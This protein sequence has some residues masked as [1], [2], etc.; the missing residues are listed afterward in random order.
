M[1]RKKAASPPIPVSPFQ[2]K[3]FWL[4]RA[5]KLR[6]AGELPRQ[7]SGRGGVVVP[8]IDASLDYLVLAEVRRAEPGKSAAER[9]AAKL[10]GARITTVY[11]NDLPAL[12]LPSREE[13]LAVLRGGPANSPTWNEMVPPHDSPARIDLSGAD[14][15]G[16][17][18]TSLRLWHCNFDGVRF[19][20]TTLEGAMIN[21]PKNVD[22]R[23]IRPP[24]RLFLIAPESCQFGGMKMYHIHVHRPVACDFTEASFVGATLS[25]WNT[26]DLIAEHANFHQVPL[27]QAKLPR[28]KLAGAIFTQAALSRALF[29]HADLRGA[30]C[31]GAN[32]RGASLR[33]ADLRRVNF[34]NANLGDADLTGAKVT[35]AD[36]T[37]AN[38]RNVNGLSAAQIAKVRPGTPLLHLEAALMVAANWRLDFT[39]MLSTGARA[40]VQFRS[41][42]NE[43]RQT[44]FRERVE[45][46]T[47]SP[48]DL[49]GALRK[50]AGVHAGAVPLLETIKVTPEPLAKQLGPL[51]VLAVCEVFGQPIT[52]EAQAVEARRAAEER[53]DRAYADIMEDLRQ[54]AAG[55]ERWNQLDNLHRKALTARQEMDLAG[56]KLIRLDLSRLDCSSPNFEGADL[57]GVNLT[58]ATLRKANLKGANLT[59]A[60]G[61]YVVLTGAN[62]LGATLR[63]A[64]FTLG[65]LGRA[66][67]RSADLTKA[68]LTEANLRGADLTGAVLTNARFD[69]AEYDARTIFPAGFDPASAKMILRSPRTKKPAPSVAPP[70]AGFTDS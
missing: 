30:N 22:F 34:R 65:R 11:E 61:L 14:L 40:D 60:K 64:D 43:V 63:G 41:R 39:T 15:S 27:V 42:T 4:D 33:N 48:N 57:T 13:A 10:T 29:D 49:L 44:I 9:K 37:G 69:R 46:C 6:G 62:L 47:S 19:E 16:L 18:L 12:L 7:I 23:T 17:D 32:L 24:T 8:D 20:D 26:T 5:V 35:G 21:A 52:T 70:S 53:A 51:P 68:F 56:C 58:C 36:F 59:Q 2:G 55:V 28:A 38:L 45:S 67:L 3:R 54:G 25:E 66:N 50:L 31:E 1:A